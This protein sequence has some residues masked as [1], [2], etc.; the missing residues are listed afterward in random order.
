MVSIIALVGALTYVALRPSTPPPAAIPLDAGPLAPAAL[1]IPSERG[2][3]GPFA[4]SAATTELAPTAPADWAMEGLN[5]GRT[6]FAADTLTL[7]LT[8]QRAVPMPADS[9]PGSPPVVARGLM[10]VETKDHL[11]AFDLRSGQERWAFSHPGAYVSPA[12]SGDRAYLRAES[13]NKGQLIALDLASGAPVWQFTPKRL[14]SEANS[15]FGG[16]LGSPLVADDTVYVGA[17][18]ELYALDAATGRTRWE[19]AAQDYVT[20]S[21][22]VAGGR[23]FIS[24]FTFVYGIDQASGALLWTFPAQSAIS[25]SP[26]AADDLVLVTSGPAVVALDAASGGKRWELSIPGEKLIP[27]A[28]SGDTAFIKSTET[29]YA[30]RLA[31]GSEAWRYHELNFVSLPALAGGQVFVVAGQ[32]ADSRVVA[33]DA[34]S[35]TSV[36]KQPVRSL[37]TTA[38]VIAGGAVYVRMDDGR[39]LGLWS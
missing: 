32:G 2:P 6:R 5:P 31:D 12:V 25:F 10:L 27:A 35:G 16:H 28:L 18:K 15:Y 22:T 39:V 21:A 29:L 37:A 38:P 23:V 34:V 3:L 11:R 36:W 30:L 33:L 7:P 8:R 24:D 26:V 14:S 19:F 13:D 9:E 20:S 1:A 17:G 4:E